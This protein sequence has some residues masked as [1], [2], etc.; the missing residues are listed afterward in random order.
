M[1]IEYAPP[2][3][4]LPSMNIRTAKRVGQRRPNTKAN[5]PKKGMKTVLDEAC[6]HSKAS[7][8]LI[9]HKLR[10]VIFTDAVSKYPFMIQT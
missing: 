10:N 4:P 1:A 6:K 8:K 5:W 3:I 2:A 9:V 7:I